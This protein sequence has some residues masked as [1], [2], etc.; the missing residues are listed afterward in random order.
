MLE[1][2]YLNIVENID[3]IIICAPT[4]LFFFFYYAKKT[5]EK[6]EFYYS[7]M[8]SILSLTCMMVFFQVPIF[9]IFLIL[10]EL[11]PLIIS[12]IFLIF[13]LWFSRVIKR[14]SNKKSHPFR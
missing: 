12:F 14:L 10:G 13:S 7:F 5:D 3:E 11:N 2:I 8:L 9:I 4:F 1:A 6:G